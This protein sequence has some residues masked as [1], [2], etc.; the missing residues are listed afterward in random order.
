MSIGRIGKTEVTQRE[1]Y[2]KKG[3]G[4]S[5]SQPKC[6]NCGFVF[7]LEELSMVQQMEAVD[8]NLLCDDCK[9]D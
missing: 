8:G 3:T 6:R 7:D 2:Q 1:N 4:G 5:K 9:K